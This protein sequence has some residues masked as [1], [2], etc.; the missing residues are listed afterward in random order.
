VLGGQAGQNLWLV[1]HST[2]T[3][4]VGVWAITLSCMKFPS[5]VS[6]GYH[7]NGKGKVKFIVEQFLKAQTGSIDIALLF[8]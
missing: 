3:M 1:S 6:V 5:F 8:L 2:K 7:L 4:L